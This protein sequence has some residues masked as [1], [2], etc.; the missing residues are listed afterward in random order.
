MP[1]LEKRATSKSWNDLFVIADYSSG[2]IT[3]TP[4]IGVVRTGQRIVYLDN[5]VVL[6]STTGSETQTFSLESVSFP[7]PE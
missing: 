6:L 4:G 1:F 3:R 7:F 2:E 5:E